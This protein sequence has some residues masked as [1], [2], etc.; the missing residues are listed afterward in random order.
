MKLLNTAK[1]IVLPVAALVAMAQAVEVPTIRSSFENA[2][3]P[4]INT[5]N[6][7]DPAYSNLLTNHFQGICTGVNP[8]GGFYLDASSTNAY[9]QSNACF[10]SESQLAAPVCGINADYSI[11]SALP[12]PDGA[13]T[14]VEP[15]LE[16]LTGGDTR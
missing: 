5:S 14:N 2:V 12:P 15:V 3:Y 13:D 16:Y 7:S 4:E 10:I 11:G 9:A 6:A 1:W 8:V